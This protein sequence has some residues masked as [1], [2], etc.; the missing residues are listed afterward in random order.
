ML[1]SKFYSVKNRLSNILALLLAILFFITGCSGG[2]ITT[3]TEITETSGTAEPSDTA[4]S[5]QTSASVATPETDEPKKK[6]AL[7]FD[8]GPHRIYT[9][10]IADE[11]E[12]YGF[13]ATFFIVGNRIDSANARSHNGSAAF[14]YILSKGNEVGI[15]GYTH[16]ANYK[17]CDDGVYEYEISETLRAILAHSAEYDVKLMRPIGGNISNERVENSPYSTILWSVDSEDWK[18]KYQAEDTEEEK[19]ERLEK[20]VDNVMSQVEDGSIILMHDIYESTYDAVKILLERLHTEGYEVVTV[21][22]LL[23]EPLPGTKYSKK[24]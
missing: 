12:K 18:L 10:G 24:P 17:T 3:Y 6:V 14:D 22:E 1:K 20:I 4:E 11:L 15:H 7:T 9:V 16:D 13:H 23:G 2:E 5:T 8:D 19:A 21:S